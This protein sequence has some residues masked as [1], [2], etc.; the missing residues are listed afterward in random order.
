[1]WVAQ[2]M[3]TP[4]QPLDIKRFGIVGM[5]TVGPESRPALRT[6]LGPDK[7]ALSHCFV[8][9]VVRFEYFGPR[10]NGL[11]FDSSAA[12]FRSASAT[13]FDFP[14]VAGRLPLRISEI[15]DSG[16]KPSIGSSSWANL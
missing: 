4:T 3:T 9:G 7:D 6:C 10:H 12:R 1:M 8:D 15:S 5:V 14:L 2:R 11:R 16:Q 13:N